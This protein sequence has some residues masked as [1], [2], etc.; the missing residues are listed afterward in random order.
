MRG[1]F[2]RGAAGAITACGVERRRPKLQRERMRALAE[3]GLVN[4]RDE[5]RWRRSGT[6][7]LALEEFQRL[8]SSITPSHAE[9]L[10]GLGRARLEQNRAADAMPSLEKAHAFW[11]EFAPDNRGAGEAALWLG[12]ACSR[13]IARRGARGVE[14]RREIAGGLTHSRRCRAGETHAHQGLMRMTP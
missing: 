8:E 11:R 9:A 7:E 13:S 6:L 10:T 14:S 3:I 12:H 5:R 1:D 2:R 4:T